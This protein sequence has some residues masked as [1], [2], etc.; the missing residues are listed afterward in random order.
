[1]LT[2]PSGK[3]EQSWVNKKHGQEIGGGFCRQP[4][5]ELIVKR[6]VWRVWRITK[7]YCKK[8]HEEKEV[9]NVM[10]TAGFLSR[11]QKLCQH[12]AQELESWDNH[13]G[14]WSQNVLPQI[15]QLR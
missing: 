11:F 15:T 12:Q 10:L 3:E 7:K 9:S 2:L 6:P 4:T 8:S 13:L 5:W 1:M 14:V